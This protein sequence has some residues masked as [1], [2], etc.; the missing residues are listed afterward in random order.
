MRPLYVE[1]YTMNVDEIFIAHVL[2]GNPG[3]MH[4][5]A[6]GEKIYFLLE[7]HLMYVEAPKGTSYSG[8]NEEELNRVLQEALLER[9]NSH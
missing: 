3:M 1:G 2:Y 4:V 6:D 5:T 9:M 7:G 8:M